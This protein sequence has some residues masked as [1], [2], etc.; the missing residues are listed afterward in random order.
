MGILSRVNQILKSNYTYYRGDIE[1]NDPSDTKGHLVDLRRELIKLKASE[2]KINMR[3]S[4]LTN[5]Y[6]LLERSAAEKLLEQNEKAARIFLVKRKEIKKNIDFFEKEKKQL[7]QIIEQYSAADAKLS[8]MIANNK[9][10]DL[11]NKAVQYAVKDAGLDTEN[12]EPL[13]NSGTFVNSGTIE[14][15]N[16]IR[17]IENQSYDPEIEQ[18]LSD[19]RKKFSS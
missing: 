14:V 19:L 9:T 12:F 17:N 11:Q 18:W 8:Q 6:D 3:I 5:E 10:A 1:T 7:L 2:Q 4:G 13:V 15:K 16:K